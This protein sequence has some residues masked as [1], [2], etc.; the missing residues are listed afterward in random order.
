MVPTNLGSNS[1]SKARKK[2]SIKENSGKLN[3]IKIKKLLLFKRYYYENEET[4]HRF[5][6]DTRQAYI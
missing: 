4:S 3:N 6:E 1:R 2:L 5:T